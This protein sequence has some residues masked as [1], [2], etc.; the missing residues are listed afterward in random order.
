[1][2]ESGALVIRGDHVA[3][4]RTDSSGRADEW[5]LVLQSQ[6]L[7]PEVVRDAG[8]FAVTRRWPPM[9]LDITPHTRTLSRNRACSSY[10]L[11]QPFVYDRKG[12]VP[13]GKE[14]TY[15][16]AVFHRFKGRLP[17]RWPPMGL[18]IT[19]LPG[20]RARTQRTSTSPRVA[21]VRA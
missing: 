2:A 18:D 13:E 5:A 11:E 3:L 4:R 6:D 14:A 20:R 12:E 1:M 21:L 15:E 16:M 19:P 7:S 8:A 9:G 17:R 10:A